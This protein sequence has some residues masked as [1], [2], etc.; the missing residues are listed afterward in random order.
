MVVGNQ[1]RRISVIGAGLMGHGIAQEFACAGYSV[2]MQDRTSDQLQQALA[3]IR[4]NLRKLATVG[5]FNESTLSDV[6]NRIETTTELAD[7]VANADIVIEAV[8]EDLPLKQ[9]LFNE[10]ERLCSPDVIFASNTSSLMPSR[11]SE[12]MKT[13]ERLVIAHYFN[14]AYLVPLVEIVPSPATSES[15]VQTV[16]NLL[17]TVGKH[18]VILR[19]EATGFVA[20]RLQ[21]ALY[22]EALAIVEQGIAA[23]EDVDEVVRFGFGRRLAA[24]GPFEIF[25]LAGLDT[26]LAVASQILP[27]V[28]APETV[29]QPIPEFFRDKV[30]RGELGVKTGQGFREWTPES[31]DELRTRLFLALTRDDGKSQVPAANPNEVH[32]GSQ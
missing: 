1:I 28:L 27:E 7:A 29:A 14:P 15:T 26:I 19:K 6:V 17:R 5:R 25:D 12:R 13:P 2:R 20:N 8:Y 32:G 4:S 11:L 10:L 16:F 21:L 22:R 9:K 31:I 23:P 30:A 18:P 3:N 24:A